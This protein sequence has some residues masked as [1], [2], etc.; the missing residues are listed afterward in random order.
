MIIIEK[1]LFGKSPFFPMT[2]GRNL[3]VVCLFKSGLDQIS[4][5]MKDKISQDGEK[6]LFLRVTQISHETS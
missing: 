3:P 4:M 6:T 2:L 1:R 5:K